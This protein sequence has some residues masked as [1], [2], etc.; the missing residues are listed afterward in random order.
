LANDD[1]TEAVLFNQIAT[2]VNITDYN[3][4]KTAMTSTINS[5]TTC[6]NLPKRKKKVKQSEKN[7]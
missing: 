6:K 3:A 4:D 5:N 2:K 7:N 1:A